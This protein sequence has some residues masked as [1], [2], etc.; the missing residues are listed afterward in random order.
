MHALQF[1]PDTKDIVIPTKNIFRSCQYLPEEFS[2]F[3]IIKH[4]P[5]VKKQCI[6]SI[7]FLQRTY[8]SICLSQ[9]KVIFTFNNRRTRFRNSVLK[10]NKWHTIGFSVTGSHVI[11][12]TDCLNVRR[13]RLKRTFPSYLEIS[14]SVIN[15]GHCDGCE[16]AFQVGS[17]IFIM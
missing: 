10:A 9:K 6:L 8:L 1:L 17:C 13:M 15:I 4:S 14:D 5:S 2:V 3:F 7:T 16:T 12:T 11:M